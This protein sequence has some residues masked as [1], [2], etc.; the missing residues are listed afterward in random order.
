MTFRKYLAVATAV[1]V[2]IL[3]I[4]V[5]AVTNLID[6]YV[7]NVDNVLSGFTKLQDKLDR[8]AARALEKGDSYVDQ[9]NHLN[10]LADEAYDASDRAARAKLRLSKL[11]D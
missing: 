5:R 2:G 3:L 11:L 1:V 9:A 8:A 6:D 7:L 10:E 4:P